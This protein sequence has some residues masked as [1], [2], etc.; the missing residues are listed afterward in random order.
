MK[1]EGQTILLTSNEPWGELWFTKHNYAFELSKKNKVFFINAPLPWKVK[2][3]LFH[4][5]DAY[6]YSE[7]LTIITYQN[8]FPL[9]NS[10]IHYYNNF[11]IS[12]SLKRFFKRNGVTDYF[13]WSFNPTVLYIPKL[14]GAKFSIFHCADKHWLDFYGTHT[15]CKHADAIFLVSKH[16]L[17]EY[18]NYK[19]PKYILHHGISKDE[20]VVEE[21]K[22]KELK[23]EVNDY[24][25]YVGV[26]D[27]RIDYELLEKAIRQNPQTSFVFIGP[28]RFSSFCL[29][30]D[31]IFNKKRYSN[32]IHLGQK[33]FKLLKYYISHAKFCISF[34][35]KN[36][37]G[38][39]IAHHKTLLY[40]AHGKPVFS[41]LFSEYKG[42]ENIMYMSENY[43][44]TLKQLG[45]FLKNGE[46]HSLKEHRI[47][48]AKEFS[49][50]NNFKKAEEFIAEVLSNKN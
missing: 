48:F 14:L 32:V 33:N 31:E 34:M 3:L 42:K 4:K 49:Y 11:L 46:D 13:L 30:A 16:I 24:G 41:Y 5:I 19:V 10:V 37:L 2:N 36:I 27:E 28:L 35:N 18:V 8:Y 38:N 22:L 7:N 39:T 26:I 45:D 47:N 1:I 20:F 12:L 6:K 17:D 15:L 29:I 25:L 23:I 40:L 21:S 50:E 9:V 43:E 44:E